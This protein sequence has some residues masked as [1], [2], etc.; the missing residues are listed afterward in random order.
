MTLARDIRLYCTP[1]LSEPRDGGL[2][3]KKAHKISYKSIAWRARNSLG[4]RGLGRT[5]YY[6]GGNPITPS[7]IQKNMFRTGHAAL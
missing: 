5:A 2:Q 7:D 4:G 3:I 1:P 6:R